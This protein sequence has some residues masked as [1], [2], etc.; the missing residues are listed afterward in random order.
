V[1]QQDYKLAKKF[2][3]DGNGVLDPDEVQVGRR[4][5]ADEFF[6]RHPDD[7]VNFGPQ[8][9]NNTRKQN[10]ERLLNSYSFE[11]AYDKLLSVERTLIAEGS[12][13][14]LDCMKDNI[15]EKFSKHKYFTNKFDATGK[16][17]FKSDFPVVL[18]SFSF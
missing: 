10:V 7:L 3:F 14:I 5:L 6:K 13:P 18:I 9:E 12:K 11:R 8:F 16:H 2:D 17:F 4:I 15:D 1:S